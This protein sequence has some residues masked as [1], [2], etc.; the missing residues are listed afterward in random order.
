M[1]APHMESY[2][3]QLPTFEG[4][5]DLL[6]RLIERQEL[7]I[8]TISLA[9]VTD[10][11]LAYLDLVEKVRPDDIADFLVVAA[12]LLL[13][14]SNALLPQ[15]PK[16]LEEDEDVGDDL[17]RQL[18]DYKRIKQAA[19]LLE[20]RYQDGLHM[21]P[22][23]VPIS[24]L[25]QNWQAHLD[26]GDTSLDDLIAALQALLQQETVEEDLELVRYTVTI[27]DKIA[28]IRSLLAGKE[29][30]AF[31]HLVHQAASRI[32]IIVTL[33]ALLEMIRARHISVQ[34]ENLFGE[35]QIT[36]TPAIPDPAS[37]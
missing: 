33:L 24:K 2:Q 3:V 1:I 16:I 32:E 8:T 25:S 6:L 17:V 20:Q 15:P 36:K 29:T 12:R 9:Q 18:Q 14:K 10:Q 11:Y 13:I 4:P 26:L 7:D 30:I 37:T 31:R 22:R 23:T 27:K 35:I 5:L 19:Q 28:Q 34:Q 21:Y